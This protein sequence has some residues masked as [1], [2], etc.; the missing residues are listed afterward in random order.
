MITPMAF[1]RGNPPDGC[2]AS[3]DVANVQVFDMGVQ[4]PTY[5]R[6][7]IEHIVVTN[8]TQSE[9]YFSVAIFPGSVGTGSPVQ[10]NPGS[11]GAASGGTP[12][13]PRTNAGGAGVAS[14]GTHPLGYY[15][16]FSQPIDPVTTLTM[17]IV[18]WAYGDEKIWVGA[19]PGHNDLL[20]SGGIAMM[21][22]GREYRD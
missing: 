16:C 19:Y 5:K 21:V 8:M 7:L 15:I 18:A 11:L 14:I 17:P 20:G 1:Y 2:A 13:L 9:G 4:C 3:N 22:S 10:Y 12:P 6:W